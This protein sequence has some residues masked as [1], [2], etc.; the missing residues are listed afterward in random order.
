MRLIF[1]VAGTG[2]NEYN[3]R[4][5][6]FVFSCAIKLQISC[7]RVYSASS[8]GKEPMLRSSEIPKKR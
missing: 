2:N 1:R 4:Q 6:R 8:Y 3:T 5:E 7:F